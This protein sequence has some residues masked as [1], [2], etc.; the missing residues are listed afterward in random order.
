MAEQTNREASSRFVCFMSCVTLDRTDILLHLSH[1]KNAL[2]LFAAKVRYVQLI[3]LMT[4]IFIGLSPIKQVHAHPHV[5][6]DCSLT[7]EF[8]KQGLKGVRQKWW[9]DEMFAAMILGDFDKNHDNKLSPDEAAALEQGAF[10]NLKN[11]D[12]FTRIFV[13]GKPFKPVEATEFKPAI[14]DGTLVYYFLVPLRFEKTPHTVKVAIFDKSFYTSI[15]MD[16]QN[17]IKG[18]PDNIKPTLA[19]EPVAEMA[20]F[21]GQIVPEAAVLTM[22]PR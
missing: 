17:N 8:D 7:F 1:M 4:I 20:Y 18:A 15:L 3:A 10:V 21:Y 9:F 12:Y 16:P 11:F 6:V 5:F 13:D 22:S 14:E 2:I 19:V